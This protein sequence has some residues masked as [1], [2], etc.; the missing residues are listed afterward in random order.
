M[1][2]RNITSQRD[3]RKLR[4]ILE[5]KPEDSQMESYWSR[6]LERNQI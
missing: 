2:L 6:A 4:N 1:A 3:L 5:I